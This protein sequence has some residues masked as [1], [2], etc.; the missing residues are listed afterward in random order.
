MKQPK[1]AGTLG[2]AKPQKADNLLF[3]ILM[4]AAY[5]LFAHPDILE[6]ARHGYIL[7]NSIRDGQFFDFYENTLSR[8]YGYDYSNAAHYNIV[9]YL[10][11]AV[12]ELPLYLWEMLTGWAF[13]DTALALWCKAIGVGFYI[14]S[15]FLMQRIAK[16]LDCDET[17]VAWMPLA[18]WLNP[19]SFF[20]VVIMGQYDSIC[21]FFLLLGL[22][23]FLQGKLWRFSLIMGIGMVCKFFPIFLLLPLVLLAEKRLLRA[24]AYVV[25]S[26]WLYIPTALLF[27]GRTGD[28]SYFN[29][30]MTER[31]FA[32]NFPGG[33]ADASYFGIAM[34]LVC[35][36]AWL[37]CPKTEKERNTAVL[38]VGLVAFG[39]L[40]LFVLWH[41]QW[42]LLLVPFVLLTTVCLSSGNRV[43]QVV[44]IVLACGFLLLAFLAF[45]GELEG[46]LLDFGLLRFW[47]G[48]PY[49]LVAQE[50]RRLVSFYIGL[51]PYAA[52][53]IPV[54]F[55]GALFAEI[56]FKF[57][58]QGNGTVAE[59]LARSSDKAPQGTMRLY[60]W[61]GFAAGVA[62]IWLLPTIF[63]YCKTLG[64]L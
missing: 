37:Y 60:I 5:L 24:A 22:L 20:T 51:V 59:R 41:P 15:G 18:F 30:L 9:V 23:Y 1:Q 34:A 58:L 38:Y 61:G 32:N 26:L 57:P 50:S 49:S 62:A 63:A 19:I 11:Y 44:D 3:G 8:V 13:S 42:L 55:Y 14:G 25:A 17:V 36:A 39:A 53:L 29:G 27:H 7:L 6:T 43:L 21:L 52:K 47:L 28:A 64:M 31:L 35:V 54:C 4:L 56:I 40:F 45:P 10:L 33:V 12:W 2:R 48:T 46:D 16:Q